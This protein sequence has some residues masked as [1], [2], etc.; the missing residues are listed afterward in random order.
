ALTTSGVVLAACVPP[1]AQPGAGQS[2]APA[3][4]AVEVRLGV[5]A[6]PDEAKFFEDWVKPYRNEGHK[7]N[8]EYVDWNTY[9]T[10]LPTQFSAGTAP[11]VMEM[12]NFTL[13]FGPQGVLAD[14]HPFL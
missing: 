10:K 4:A 12:S 13:Q 11:D 9:W 8:I 5:W 3:A 2:S 6:S 14:L 7:V 1:A